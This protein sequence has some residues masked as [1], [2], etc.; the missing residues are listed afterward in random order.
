MKIHQVILFTLVAFQLSCSSDKERAKV[1]HVIIIGIDGMSVGGVNLANTPT[2]DEIKQ[3]GCYSFNAR[4]VFPT[5]SSP[6]WNT[7]LTSA[8]ASMTG[9]SSNDWLHDNFR[10]PP[11]RITENGW[12]PDVFY[13]L[14]KADKNLKTASVYH[15]SGFGNLYDNSFVDI[16]I[17]SKDEYTTTEDAIKVIKEEKP[18]FLFIQLDHVDDWGHT[19]GHMTPRYL[20]SVESADS[21]AGKIIDAVKEA[22]IFETSLIVINADHGGKG[23]GH[24]HE[25]VEGN[26][27]P[28]LFYGGKVK[29]TGEL[30]TSVT[31]F[32][33]APLSVYAL[34]H[35]SPDVWLGSDLHSI[36]VDEKDPFILGKFMA[37]VMYTP[38]ILPKATNGNS[39]GLYIN[40]I[41][42]VTINSI[43]TDGEI[44]YTLDGTDPTKD[45]PKYTEPLK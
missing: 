27:V 16:D 26:T 13:V 20:Q 2:F 29:K 41:P 33:L 12:F 42:K 22:G 14:K 39:G 6:N 8:T 44:H 7:M 30:L 40:E 23:Y 32:N 18:N 3:N 4:D 37:P 10:L 28:Y 19:A 5:S 1:N 35:E 9:V 38:E 21:L 24:G 25:S 43:A 11:M 31:H 34:G 45:S 15:W 17:D 36:F